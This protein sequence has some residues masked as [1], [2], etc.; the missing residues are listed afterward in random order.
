MKGIKDMQRKTLY[1]G[2]INSPTD[3]RLAQARRLL[4]TFDTG[5]LL[6]SSSPGVLIVLI[7]QDGEKKGLGKN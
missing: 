5:Y 1:H 2:L 4:S 7:G 6:K 3:T